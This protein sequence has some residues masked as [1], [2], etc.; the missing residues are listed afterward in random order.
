MI[1]KASDREFA[2]CPICLGDL[3][4][5]V[6]QHEE[7]HRDAV[8]SCALQYICSGECITSF[9]SHAP[10][11]LYICV[12]IMLRHCL[13]PMLPPPPPPPPAPHCRNGK[14]GVAYL[15]CTHCFH[16]GAWVP[17]CLTPE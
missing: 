9:G 1:S 3:H 8:L 12:V 5:C 2:D 4:R 7:K 16:V 11:F 14:K 10:C 13:I 6:N 17:L 15:S